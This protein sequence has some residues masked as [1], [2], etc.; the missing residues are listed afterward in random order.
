MLEGKVA[1]VTGAAQGIGARFAVGLAKEGARVIVA[2]V[3][4]GNDVVGHYQL[5]EKIKAKDT[6]GGRRL[7]KR[8]V[9]SSKDHIIH[10][11]QM[12]EELNRA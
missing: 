2:D 6:R 12:D 4:D 8:H 11:L 3:L 9:Q 5:I 7:M 1:I 10:L